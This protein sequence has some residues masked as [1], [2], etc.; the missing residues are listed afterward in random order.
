[1]GTVSRGSFDG[2]YLLLNQEVNE[3]VFRPSFGVGI[4]VL[5]RHL[6]QKELTEV[7]GTI[8]GVPHPPLEDLLGRDVPAR[9]RFAVHRE[10]DP[11][12]IINER[13]FLFVKERS[14]NESGGSGTQLAKDPK[15]RSY[16]RDRHSS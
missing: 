4:Y 15:R 7:P 16:P 6:C 14:T 9:A 12:E 10:Y 1:M 5:C 13:R 8:D 3:L 11:L 2:G